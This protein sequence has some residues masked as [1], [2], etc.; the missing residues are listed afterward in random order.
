MYLETEDAAGPVIPSRPPPCAHCKRQ[1]AAA[2]E[3]REGAGCETPTTAEEEDVDFQQLVPLLR[4]PTF[5]WGVRT[6]EIFAG[7]GRWS[8]VMA[9]A[10]WR[11]SPWS[12]MSNHSRRQG[13]EQTT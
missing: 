4:R 11:R 9:D 7:T 3:I 10:S 5:A 2:C 12:S 13:R 6:R 8:A 1:Q